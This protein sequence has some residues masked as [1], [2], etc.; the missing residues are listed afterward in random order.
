M[1]DQ[2]KTGI[3]TLMVLRHAEKE[4][5]VR[6]EHP[7]ELRDQSS[8]RRGESCGFFRSFCSSTTQRKCGAKSS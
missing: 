2:T 8:T 7:A 5:G 1:S 4:G 6:R 3:C